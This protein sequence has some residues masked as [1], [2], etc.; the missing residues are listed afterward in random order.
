MFSIVK[1]T[2]S[3]SPRLRIAQGMFKIQ[4][5]ANASSKEALVA[6]V[7]STPTVNTSQIPEDFSSLTQYL[8]STVGAKQEPFVPNPEAW[9]NMPLWKFVLREYTRPLNRWIFIL[10][11]V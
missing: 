11:P 8:S 7:A 5:V 9:Q 4:A 10:G 2:M 3:S 6:A 1:R